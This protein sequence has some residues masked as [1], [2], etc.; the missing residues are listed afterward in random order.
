MSSGRSV[1]HCS[2][3]RLLFLREQHHLLGHVVEQQ[4]VVNFGL[5]HKMHQAVGLLSPMFLKAQQLHEGLR[6]FNN[7]LQT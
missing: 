5:H 4:T 7:C 3:T 6:W 2:N 1:G